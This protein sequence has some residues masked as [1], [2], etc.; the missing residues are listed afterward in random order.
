MT[1]VEILAAEEV[2]V[3]YAF[4]WMYALIWGGLMVLLFVV[5][6]VILNAYERGS[7][8][9]ITVIG[10]VLGL[11]IGGVAGVSERTPISYETQ[12]KVTISSEVK[13]SD[14]LEKY[15]VVD[16]EGR[17]YTVREKNK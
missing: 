16:S 13:M 17:I 9:G 3:E 1:G 7:L 10:L 14:F 15:E 8:S 12:Y 4:N 11:Y 2:V 6:D 5:L